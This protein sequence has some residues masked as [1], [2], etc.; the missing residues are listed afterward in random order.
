MSAYKIAHEFD[1][2]K[3]WGHVRVNDS[4]WKEVVE[5]MKTPD[6][7]SLDTR[8]EESKKFYSWNLKMSLKNSVYS[9]VT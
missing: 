5:N 8:S 2:W 6:Q 9:S 3:R 1:Q 4:I 7:N